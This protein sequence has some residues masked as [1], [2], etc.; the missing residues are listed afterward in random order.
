MLRHVYVTNIQCIIPSS[1]IVFQIVFQD[2]HFRT[3]SIS[4][5]VVFQDSEDGDEI[6]HELVV[7]KNDFECYELLIKLDEEGHYVGKVSYEGV[8]IGPPRF[9]IISLSGKGNGTS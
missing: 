2:I 8:R 1:V 4:G 5:H 9:T 7:Y 3:T 6:C